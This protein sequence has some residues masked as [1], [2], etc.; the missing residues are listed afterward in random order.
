M[1]TEKPQLQKKDREPNWHIIADFALNEMIFEE[2]AAGSLFQAM[3]DLAIPPDCIE[4]VMQTMT[5]IVRRVSGAKSSPGLACPP[6][7]F[8]LFYK[9]N[10]ADRVT[11]L[12]EQRRGGWGYYVIERG[13]DSSPIPGQESGRIVELYVYREGKQ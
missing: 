12:G 11:P 7:R 4:R 2:L 3:Q 8:R 9:K 13:S 10:T 1:K 6:I 5:G